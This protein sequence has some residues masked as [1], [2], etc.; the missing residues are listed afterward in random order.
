MSLKRLP[1]RILPLAVA[2]GI[3]GCGDDNIDPYRIN[4]ANTYEFQSQ[5]ESSA[6]SVNHI[7][8]TTALIL[9]EELRH[10]IESDYL[11]SFGQTYGYQ[12][13]LSLLNRVYRLGTNTEE[14]NSLW[15][16]D[17]Y[18]TSRMASTAVS[19]VPLTN[20]PINYNQLAPNVSLNAL[21]PGLQYPLHNRKAPPGTLPENESETELIGD[22]IGWRVVGINDGD[23]IFNA[24]IQEWF[25][26]IANL[27]IDSDPDTKFVLNDVNYKSL[28]I[29]T[30]RASIPY[31]QISYY[32][33][34]PSE[35]LEAS[36]QPSESLQTILESMWDAAFGYSG[37]PAQAS[38]IQPLTSDSDN[39]LNELGSIQQALQERV[40]GVG[41]LALEAVEKSPLKDIS[42]FNDLN[43]HF[44]IGRSL[45]SVSQPQLT[46][47]EIDTYL[48]NSQS[49]ILD[50]WE[51]AIVAKAISHINWVVNEGNIVKITKELHSEYIE[52]WA[53]LKGYM[54][55]LQFNPNSIIS[56]ETLTE[57]H[58]DI[59]NYPANAN[60][61][62]NFQSSLVVDRTGDQAIRN[63]LKELYNLSN[64]NIE[65]W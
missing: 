9:I 20:T 48:A 1:F 28:L 32:Y 60:A 46:Q 8:A 7:E 37:I 15:N 50:T 55:A 6:N 10:L 34:N 3:A 38:D 33:L 44:L 65:A 11:Q 56:A 21:A 24:M 42:Y 23:D 57:I 36:N 61:V 40:H 58:Q 5:N 19:G 4:T 54:L 51:R 62:R 35:L 53:N 2:I 43:K 31:S 30:L 41:L 16:S 26:K 45:M 22:F 29:A 52:A 49:L 17:L 39:W 63:K 18:D 64:S 27:A 47:D 13:T 14:A 59:G 12:E 25:G